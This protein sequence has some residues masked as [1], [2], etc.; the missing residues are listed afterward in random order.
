MLKGY[1]KELD[2]MKNAVKVKSEHLSRLKRAVYVLN[3][4]INKR[5]KNIVDELDLEEYEEL[6]D[7]GDRPPL[8]QVS[9]NEDPEQDDSCVLMDNNQS[10]AYAGI[11]NDHALEVD[12]DFSLQYSFVTDVRQFEFHAI[13]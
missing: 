5:S 4:A 10:A 11:M 3:G 8:D 7:D 1:R 6:I 13:D 12:P 9:S 2:D